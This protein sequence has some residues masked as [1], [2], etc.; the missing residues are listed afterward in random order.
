MEFSIENKTETHSTYRVEKSDNGIRGAEL[1]CGWIL[2][3]IGSEKLPKQSTLRFR[4]TPRPPT[5]VS[6]L[7]IAIVCFFITKNW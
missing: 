4:S 1:R 5:T 3:Q 2:P 6:L 7:S